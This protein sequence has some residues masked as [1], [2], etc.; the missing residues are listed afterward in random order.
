MNKVNSVVPKVADA[1]FPVSLVH[2]IE[3]GWHWAWWLWIYNDDMPETKRIGKKCRKLTEVMSEDLE[4]A[5]PRVDP[6]GQFKVT[7]VV[8]DKRRDC[9]TVDEE[10]Q[11]DATTHAGARLV[12]ATVD[13]WSYSAAD[14]ETFC[15]LK[16]Q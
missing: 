1:D 7:R 12:E 5:C 13:V 15:R 11:D 14:V 8:A 4:A 6:D 3:V 16:V 9:L 10:L 2:D